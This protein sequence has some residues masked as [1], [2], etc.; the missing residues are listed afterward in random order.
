MNLLAGY[1]DV[2]TLKDV[3]KILRCG[4][5]AGLKLLGTGGIKSF[6]VGNAY[7]VLKVNMIEYLTGLQKD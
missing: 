2:L 6:K 1:P 7:R 4:R 5:N 3:C